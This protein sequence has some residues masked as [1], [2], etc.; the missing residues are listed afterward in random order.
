MSSTVTVALVRRAV[1]R[2]RTPSSNMV[3][4]SRSVLR[5]RLAFSSPARIRRAR[6]PRQF[7]ERLRVVRADPLGVSPVTRGSTNRSPLPDR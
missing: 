4:F 5:V 6:L 7:R 1:A 2:W 3:V